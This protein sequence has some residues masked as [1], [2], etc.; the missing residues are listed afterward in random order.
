MHKLTKTYRRTEIFGECPVEVHV[1]FYYFLRRLFYF[2][3]RPQNVPLI[4][5]MVFLRNTKVFTLIIDVQSVPYRYQT[6]RMTYWNF[7]GAE[8]SSSPCNAPT[9]IIIL[10][11]KY[12]YYTRCFDTRFLP[13]LR[14]L[15]T[16]LMKIKNK[17]VPVYYK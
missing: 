12:N 6:Y 4:I 10:L 17:N 9:S 16:D 8:T 13:F 1:C 2:V 11:S 15:S 3:G 7:S 14:L 5:E